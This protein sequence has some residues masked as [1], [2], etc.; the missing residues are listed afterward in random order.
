[1]LYRHNTY[2]THIHITD[3]HTPV[4]VSEDTLLDGDKTVPLGSVNKS[5]ELVPI[6]PSCSDDDSLDAPLPPKLDCNIA[7]DVNGF[8]E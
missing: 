8:C 2:H 1:M 6:L 5:D 7:V 4:L 3:A